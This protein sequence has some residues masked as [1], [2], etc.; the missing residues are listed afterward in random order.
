MM[1]ERDLSMTKIK[2]SSLLRDLASI[3]T[4]Y[5]GNAKELLPIV[6]KPDPTCSEEAVAAGIDTLIFVSRNKRA[7]ED[8]F[9]AN[10]ELETMLRQGQ[11]C[12]GNGAQYNSRWCAMYVL[13]QAEQLG[14]GHAVLCAERVVECNPHSL[15]R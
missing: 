3:F 14:L 11:R 10:I 12:A 2:L 4:R 9:D 5:Q 15:G 7:I 6:D 8:H 13:R 1:F